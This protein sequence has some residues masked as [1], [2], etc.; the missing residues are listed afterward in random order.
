M[1]WM[2]F[3]IVRPAAGIEVEKPGIF[4]FAPPVLVPG[5]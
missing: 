1:P 4:P 5:S 3:L 2:I